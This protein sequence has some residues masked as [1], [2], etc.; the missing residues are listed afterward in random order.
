MPSS[1]SALDVVDEQYETLVAEVVL[2]SLF[3]K[4]ET[5]LDSGDDSSDDDRDDDDVVGWLLSR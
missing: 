1:M 3:K 4:K 2:D 5:V